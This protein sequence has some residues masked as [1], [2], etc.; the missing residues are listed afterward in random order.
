MN[1]KL[2]KL[3]MHGLMRRKKDI[4]RACLATFF[5]IFFI[6]G[7][8]LFQENMYQ[9]QMVKNRKQF[10]DW[11]AI[12]NFQQTTA[13]KDNEYLTPAV[14][15]GKYALIYDDKWN[16]TRI[17]IGYMT[18]EFIDKGNIRIA[19]GS[20]P[21]EDNEIACDYNTLSRLGYTS[22]LGQEITIN[23]YYNDKKST[24]QKKQAKFILSGVM[25]NFTDSWSVMR[26]VPGALLTEH[27]SSKLSANCDMVYM[28]GLKDHI[29]TNDYKP[30]F[31]KLSS[32]N[33]KKINYNADV[34]EF[35][36]W[37]P[38][39]IY[40]YIYFL[41]MTIGIAALT[42]QIISYQYSRKT[43]YQKLYRLGATRRTVIGCRSMENLIILIPTGLI[44]IITAVLT[45]R[46]IGWILERKIGVAF[47]SV[48]IMIILKSLLALLFALISA[49]LVAVFVTFSS[50]MNLVGDRVAKN[51]KKAKT[52]EST[53]TYQMKL[54]KNNVTWQMH[55]RLTRSNGFAM[56]IGAR[57][58]IACITL[59]ILFCGKNIID[60]VREYKENDTKA[61]ITGFQ[62]A[63]DGSV[64]NYMYLSYDK[65]EDESDYG[66]I[67]GT[68]D[69]YLSKQV[70]LMDKDSYITLR[71]KEQDTDATANGSKVVNIETGDTLE[72]TIDAP[73]ASK[74]IID[75]PLTNRYC[76]RG[77]TTIIQGMDE[78]L[79]DMVKETSGI[80][81]LSYSTFETARDWDWDE[82]KLKN[83]GLLKLTSYGTKMSGFSDTYLYA[84]EYVDPTEELYK[85]LSKYMDSS[86]IDYD[87]FKNGDQIVMFLQKNVNQSIDDTIEQGTQINFHYYRLPI[88]PQLC[89]FTNYGT[90]DQNYGE[91]N[92]P[93]WE[94]MKTLTM[95]KYFKGYPIQQGPY[96]D[97]LYKATDDA[98]T[99]EF[100]ALYYKMMYEPAVSTKVAAVVN[101]T[102]EVKED[103][104]DI[105]ADYGYYTAV[106]SSELGKKACEK[107]NELAKEVLQDQ[108]T[109]E[110]DCEFCYNQITAKYNLSSSFSATDNILCSY[111]RTNDVIYR[112]MASEMEVYRTNALNAILQ[113]GITMI[114]TIV[115]NILIYSI[116]TR[117]RLELYRHKFELL[118]R[119]GAE[120][121]QIRR[122]CMI[123]IVRESLWCIFTLPI[124]IL[125]QYIICRNASNKL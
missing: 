36:P 97:Y 44:G 113:Y 107:Q 5:A 71:K 84:T 91:P 86:V 4:V 19:K 32:Y 98:K 2:S 68:P 60:A 40:N 110:Y 13:L 51:K 65:G 63:A 33:S 82:M 66:Y 28:Y 64:G 17:N 104:S 100:Y 114:A 35:E 94:S 48:T 12:E 103:L 6:S 73:D 102:D 29:R 9:W 58:F 22:E 42:Y 21:K 118:V 59:V 46:I 76:K 87:A 37:G 61:D 96:T 41:V 123:E 3:L 15:A 53:K 75:I 26:Y 121:K 120:K 52:V 62:Q 14:T 77:N 27:G 54:R 78:H 25:E 72:T 74:A 56:K 90:L 117:N 20:M 69:Y 109:D 125:I 108:Y 115:I 70:K 7:L 111:F 124:Q 18:P 88:T 81:D 89:G 83:M 105:L 79:I 8:L 49:E 101:V 106:A 99:D 10:G 38:K 112:S 119:L 1:S 11:F 39:N 24:G 34:Y 85:R 31:E 92:Y 23:Y 43:H 57:I 93:Y 45:G 122:I 116:L 16:T 95:G 30:I 50:G 80:S 47:Y 67:K 55:K